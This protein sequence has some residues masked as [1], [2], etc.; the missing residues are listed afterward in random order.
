MASGLTTPA[1]SATGETAGSAMTTAAERAAAVATGSH[2]VDATSLFCS[3]GRCP[4]VIDGVPVRID[5]THST[6]DYAAYLAPAMGELLV[7]AVESD[8]S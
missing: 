7:R 1:R 3:Q 5:R 2:F 6:I 4:A 8:G